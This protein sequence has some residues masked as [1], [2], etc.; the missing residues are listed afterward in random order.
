MFRQ[1]LSIARLLDV[2]CQYIAF[3]IDRHDDDNDE[4]CLSASLSHF[5]SLVEGDVISTTNTSRKLSTNNNRAS[6][7]KQKN[8]NGNTLLYL[9]GDA[10]VY[11]LPSKKTSVSK[12]Y[13]AKSKD[14]FLTNGETLNDLKRRR[15]KSQS[16]EGGRSRGTTLLS[17]LERMELYDKLNGATKRR[18][19]FIL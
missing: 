17:P 4:N 7:L 12:F 19:C 11:D 8:S 2:T 3:Q 5:S 10:G 6:D 16:E 14:S 15:S 1:N 18:S 13:L 9:N